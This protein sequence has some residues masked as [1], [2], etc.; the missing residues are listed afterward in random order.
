MSKKALYKLFGGSEPPTDPHG[1]ILLD[2]AELCRS[3]ADELLKRIG[4]LGIRITPKKIGYELRCADPVAFDAVYTREL[5]Y[6]AIEAFVHGHSAA[7]IVRENGQ[8]KPVQF[9]DLMDPATGRI[10]TRL[11]DCSSQSFRVARVYMW[12]MSQKDWNNQALVER[13]AAASKMTVQELTDKFK[14]VASIVID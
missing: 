9:K 6:C 4:H 11:V 7:L 1:H 8:V 12:R 10:R 3:V 5:G 13:V 2:D 14:R